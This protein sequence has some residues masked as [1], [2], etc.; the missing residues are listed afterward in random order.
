MKAGFTTRV[1]IKHP[2][3]SKDR[4]NN[5]QFDYDVEAVDVPDLVS[6]QPTSSVEG[7]TEG[8]LGTI[9]TFRLYTQPGKDIDLSSIDRVVDPAGRDL[10]VLGEVQRWPHPMIVGGVHHAEVDLRYVKG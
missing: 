6:L 7:T 10:E 1:K 4:Y 2:T 9:Q 8:R 3:V 5:D